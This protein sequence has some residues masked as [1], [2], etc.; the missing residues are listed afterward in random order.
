[1]RNQRI[2][3]LALIGVMILALLIFVPKV[4]ELLRRRAESLKCAN[5]I[6]SIC[7]AARL[8]AN[9]H[10]GTF[11]TNFICMSN[12]LVTPKILTCLRERRTTDWAAFSPT[13]CT[14]E[15]GTPGV[16]ENATNTI[17]L[18]CTVHGHLGYPDMT[19]FDGHR[20]RG[21]SFL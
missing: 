13:N 6:V 19:V 21:K 4:P 18:R 9:D 20:R 15:I 10:E 8:W 2:Y 12:E 17:F 11:P 3:A 14:Y 16:H 1:M 5:T 7:C